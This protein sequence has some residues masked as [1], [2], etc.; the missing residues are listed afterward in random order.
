MNSDNNTTDN[1]NDRS[2][3]GML[4]QLRLP[5]NDI[6]DIVGPL[7]ASAGV[8]TAGGTGTGRALSA[9]R[10]HFAAAHR[11]RGGGCRAGEW[12]SGVGQKLS[13]NAWLAEST[14]ML[15]QIDKNDVSSRV[16]GRS[17]Q[18]FMRQENC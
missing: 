2:V 4:A 3:F 9:C 17:S 12:R 10:R 1:Q 15:A 13:P 14:R 6:E 5:A 16:V 7:S 11:W 18:A 8:T